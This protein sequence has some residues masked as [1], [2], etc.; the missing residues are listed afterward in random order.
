MKYILFILLTPI[1]SAQNSKHLL[2]SFPMER[3]HIAPLKA[4]VHHLGKNGMSADVIEVEFQYEKP[5]GSTSS[6][7]IW[8]NGRVE[9]SIQLAPSDKDAGRIKVALDPSRHSEQ[10]E[11]K[12][13]IG[14]TAS[15]QIQT[16]TV[17]LTHP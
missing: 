2:D 14:N 15:Q 16:T 10:I 3:A 7:L 8:A 1:L 9:K 6:I 4:Q 11:L 13:W 17:Q 5:S 12:Y